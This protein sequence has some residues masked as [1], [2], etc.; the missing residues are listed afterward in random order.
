MILCRGGRPRPPRERSERPERECIPQLSVV[1]AGSLKAASML[2]DS[3]I[4]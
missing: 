3:A 2:S 4:L 1:Y